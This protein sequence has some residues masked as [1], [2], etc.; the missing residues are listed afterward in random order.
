MGGWQIPA[1]P[2][3]PSPESLANNP[4]TI[5]RRGEISKSHMDHDIVAA[6]LSIPRRIAV[7]TRTVCTWVA[8]CG[9]RGIWS[10]NLKL[11]LLCKK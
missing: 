9:A 10:T 6:V 7:T 4:V 3:S 11:M 1:L 8:L 5:L 2:P